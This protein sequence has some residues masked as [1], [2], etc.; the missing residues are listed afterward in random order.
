MPANHCLWYHKDLSIH[1]FTLAAI[2]IPLLP[3][4]PFVSLRRYANHPYRICEQILARPQ[5]TPASISH[6]S[7]ARVQ[8]PASFVGGE[9][10]VGDQ[11][12]PP[13]RGAGNAGSTAGE[14]P[15]GEDQQRRESEWQQRLGELAVLPARFHLLQQLNRGVSEALRYVDL[16][17]GD[18]PWSVAGLLSRCRHLVFFALRQ[19]VWRA[20][21]ARTSRPAAAA[22]AAHSSGEA[23][24]PSLQLR[25]S[26]GRAARHEGSDTLRADQN[27]RQALFCQAFFSLRNKEESLFRLRPGE[28][29]YSTV[30]V[31]EHAHD[32]GGTSLVSR[33]T[34]C[35]LE[36]MVFWPLVRTCVRR[37]ACPLCLRVFV[38]LVRK[39]RICCSLPKATRRSPRIPNFDLSAP[40]DNRLDV[41]HVGATSAKPCVFYP[42]FMLAVPPP[43]QSVTVARERHFAT[44][45]TT[46]PSSMHHTR[47]RMVFPLPPS[48]CLSSRPVPRVIRRVLRRASVWCA[49]VADQ[50]S[51]LGERR[52]HQP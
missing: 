35:C 40:P 28:V 11:P 23:T 1:I 51:Q 45:T 10:V 4:P 36:V 17:Q 21:L 48:S 8:S 24:P 14:T 42:R 20:E 5:Q 12:P 7:V 50:V 32:A 46:Y 22:A 16:S 13:V 31:G 3:S 15:G 19:E 52:R 25:L 47:S 49:A 43:E 39:R 6:V 44:S 9:T 2:A 27:G 18:L 41:H 26:R 29:L 34:C 33:S 38:H 37:S 30:F